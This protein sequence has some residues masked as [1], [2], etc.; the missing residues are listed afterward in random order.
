MD[1]RGGQSGAVSGRN[2]NGGTAGSRATTRCSGSRAATRSAW[3][4]GVGDTRLGCSVKGGGGS[5][6]RRWARPQLRDG[7][8][9]LSDV[10]RR[11]GAGVPRVPMGPAGDS[12]R[13]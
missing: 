9:M 6:L 13:G 7:Q 3:L 11:G 12:R 2:V 10:P 1:G 4:H 8:A 5:W